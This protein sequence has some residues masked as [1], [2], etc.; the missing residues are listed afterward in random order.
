[1]SVVALGILAG[2][3][4]VGMAFDRFWAPGIAFATMLLPAVAA[5]LLMGTAPV[6]ARVMTGGFL[7]GFAAGAESD[8]IAFLAARYF[9][10]AHYGR[11]YG[12]LYLPFGIGSAVSPIRRTLSTGRPPSTNAMA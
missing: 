12:W 3:V 10:M 9:G 11:I 8:V 5:V 1:M 4:I 2:R 6:L 7:L